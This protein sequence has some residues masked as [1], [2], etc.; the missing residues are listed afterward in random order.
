MQATWIPHVLLCL[1]I[2]LP[3]LTRWHSNGRKLCEQQGARVKDGQHAETRSELAIVT[4]GQQH[5]NKNPVCPPLTCPI[6]P[7]DV[8]RFCSDTR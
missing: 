1:Y 7:Y 3:G 8:Q 5:N 4:E 2:W 6:G